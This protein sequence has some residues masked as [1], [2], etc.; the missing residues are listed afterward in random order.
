MRVYDTF[1][2]IYVFDES[3]PGLLTANFSPKCTFIY[4]WQTNN[5]LN[6]SQNNNGSNNFP[7]LKIYKIE[8]NKMNNVNIS[9]KLVGQFFLSYRYNQLFWSNDENIVMYI[10]TETLNFFEN[11]NFENVSKK[12]NI[13]NLCDASLS[14]QNNL[15]A[16]HFFDKKRNVNLVR[17]F[18]Y[19][20]FNPN[21][22]I[23]STVLPIGAKNVEFKWNPIGTSC[24]IIAEIESPGK[25]YYDERVLFFISKNGDSQNLLLKPQSFQGSSYA[26]HDIAWTPDGKKFAVIHGCIYFFLLN[27]LF[28]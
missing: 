14:P 23:C 22:C 4:S 18:K 2:N 5:Q 26:I 6:N 12:I 27:L 8:M 9:L 15:V 16:I 13:P 11:L 17:M 19:P 10:E 24:I 28:F 25:S 20:N 3:L 7:N 1:N 21:S